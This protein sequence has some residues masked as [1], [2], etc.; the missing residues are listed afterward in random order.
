MAARVRIVDVAKV[1]RVVVRLGEALVDVGLIDR[2]P[3]RLVKVPR[4]AI[5]VVRVDAK[6][7]G[8][9]QGRVG[10]GSVHDTLERLVAPGAHAIAA[11]A[12]LVIA[13]DGGLFDGAVE[14]KVSLLVPVGQG[15]LVATLVLKELLLQTKEQAVPW[16]ECSVRVMV[17]LLVFVVF[18]IGG[19][20][21]ASC[22][23]YPTPWMKFDCSEWRACSSSHR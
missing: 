6:N 5:L 8:Y 20:C 2:L 14:F 16:E 22:M 17:F 10:K 21:L 3:R 12:V 7:L 18:M 13:P 23:T 15:S 19:H 11:E 9:P 1:G 4:Q